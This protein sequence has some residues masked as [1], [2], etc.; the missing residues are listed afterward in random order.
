MV[1][2]AHIYE[3][4]KD[5]IVLDF[6][7][8][9]FDARHHVAMWSALYKREKGRCFCCRGR[10]GLDMSFLIPIA[11]GGS[12]NMTN[13]VLACR[14]CRDRRGAGHPWSD[15]QFWLALSMEAQAICLRW[16]TDRF[17]GRP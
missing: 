8:N 2:A 16:Y 12:R 10:G 1:M 11:S 4:D 13:V 7:R 3:I 6:S 9:T 14:A 5:P 15:R 17:A